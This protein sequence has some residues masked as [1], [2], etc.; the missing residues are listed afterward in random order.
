MKVGDQVVYCPQKKN[1]LDNRHPVAVIDG[2][3]RKGLVRIK[4][5]E[6]DGEHKATVSAVRLEANQAELIE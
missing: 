3:T 1:E 2:F 5:R 4:W 6:T